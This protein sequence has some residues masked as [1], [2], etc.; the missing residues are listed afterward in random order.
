MAGTDGSYEFLSKSA[1]SLRTGIAVD[2]QGVVYV[3]NSGAGT[4]VKITKSVIT[5]SY[6]TSQ[7]GVGRT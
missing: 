3:A 2:G 7:F 1:V 5:N 6:I 4:V